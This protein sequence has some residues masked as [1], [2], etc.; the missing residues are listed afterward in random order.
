MSYVLNYH[1]F[2]LIIIYIKNR[3]YSFHSNV[4]I[5]YVL[6]YTPNYI[7]NVLMSYIHKHFRRLQEFISS[8]I[9]KF[10]LF[11]SYKVVILKKIEW[12]RN[13]NSF[14]E[15]PYTIVQSFCIFLQARYK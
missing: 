7:P 14:S 13:Q 10:K 15:F 6:A 9:L 11:S 8:T 5:S 4:L 3:A 1:Y 2:L 12:I